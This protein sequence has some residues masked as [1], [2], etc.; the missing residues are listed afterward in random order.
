MSNKVGQFGNELTSD[1]ALTLHK[2]GGS[3]LADPACYQRVADL[4]LQYGQPTD[5]VVVSAA[6]KTTNQLLALIDMAATGVDYHVQLTQLK[7]YQRELVESLLSDPQQI[8]EL[9][10]SELDAL[11]SWL[12]YEHVDE[13]T[14]N[15]IMACGEVWSSRLLS[16]L[17]HEKGRASCAIDARQ[18]LVAKGIISPVVDEEESQQLFNQLCNDKRSIQRVITGFICRNVEN[19][20]LTLGR[21]GSDYSATLIAQLAGASAVNIW[22]DVAGV[23]SA[24]PNLINEA[25]LIEQL[26]LVEA[27]ELA[28]LGNPVL[29]RRTLQPLAKDNIALR[30]RSSFTPDAAFTEIGR[31]LGHVGDCIVNGSQDINVYTFNDNVSNR[32]LVNEL[33]DNGFF[34]LISTQHHEKLLLVFPLEMATTFESYL[35][36]RVE[37]GFN[38]DTNSGVI[39]LLDAGVSWYRK[40]FSK[41]FAK[42]SHWPIVLSENGLSL[43]VIVP[44]KRVNILTYLLHQR[45]YSPAKRIGIVL[46]G[47]GNIGQQWLT[48]FNQQQLS[49]ENTFNMSLP[50]VGIARSNSILIDYDG[51]DVTNWQQAFADDGIAIEQSMISETLT[52]H[53]FDD[54]IVL[55]VS[56]AQTLTD[57]YPDFL[58]AGF[59][60]ISANKLAGSAPLAFYNEVKQLSYANNCKWL[61]NASVG[62]GLPILHSI[63]D[64]YRSGDKIESI[65]GV[66][67]GTLSWL[68]EHYDNSVSFSTL[69]TKALSLGITEPDP[70]DDLSGKD[71]QRKL[72]ILARECGLDVELSDIEL[73]SMV[74]ETLSDISLP[75]FL[76]RCHELDD[77]MAERYE[78][79]KLNHQVIRYVAEFTNV[80]GEFSASV[81]LKTLDNNHPFASLTPSDNV[82][83]VKSVWYQENPLVIRGPGAGREVTAAAIES[84]LYNLLKELQ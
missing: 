16:A 29:H 55:D 13:F 23:F 19:Q 81:G 17:L 66:F 44:E 39:S 14:A 84:D 70:R 8:L 57:I 46:M 62:A 76:E 40:L 5:V 68:F 58:N 78:Q 7:T 52:A 26:S 47:A 4:L 20:T 35:D 12:C 67:S 22:T 61:Y 15:S 11:G 6:G 77:A 2:F 43:S 51:I 63:N 9:L 48:L 3:S 80:D 30:V 38:C 21:N 37:D 71:K 74:P 42:E 34:P 1:S 79:A 28:R 64:L 56:A 49:L 53:P 72:L 82:F 83:L 32:Q 73:H 27:E 45:I 36:T 75:E 54:L 59:H 41:I 60:L 24:D 33:A 18:F 69:L 65:S 50:L 31:R 10:E 25:A